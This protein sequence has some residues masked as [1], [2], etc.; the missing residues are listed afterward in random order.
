MDYKRN[1]K[2]DYIYNQMASKTINQNFGNAAK[3]VL[4]IYTIYVFIF[5]FKKERFR[6]HYLCFYLKNWKKD[7]Q[8]KPKIEGQSEEQKSV[9][10][11]KMDKQ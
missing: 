3:T 9:M 1:H 7:E 10:I 8:I 2:R 11:Q 4:R 5:S 6:I